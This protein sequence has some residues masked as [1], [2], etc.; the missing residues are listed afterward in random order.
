M[1]NSSD[2]SI[3]TKCGKPLDLKK[4]MELEEKANQQNFMANKLAG[5]ILVQMLMTGQIPKLAKNEI[6]SLKNSY[7]KTLRRVSFN[8]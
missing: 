3:C 5:K 4:A 8:T 6:N 2:S 1:T 7:F